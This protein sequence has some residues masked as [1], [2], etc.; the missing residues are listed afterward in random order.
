MV[1]QALDLLIPRLERFEG[2]YQACVQHT[3][4]RLEQTPVGHL[5]REGVLEG[6]GN[7]GEEACLVE[8]L[9]GLQVGETPAELRLGQ[10]RESLEQGERY[11]HANDGGDL[12][13]ALLL[14]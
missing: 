5:L 6:V 7:L 3:P 8:E 1:G 14:Q 10:L 12:H 4:P 9:D 11:L 2:V 13:E